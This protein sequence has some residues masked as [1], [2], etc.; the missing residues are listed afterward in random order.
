MGDIA[1]DGRERNVAPAHVH[2]ASIHGP[3]RSHDEDSRRANLVPALKLVLGLVSGYMVVEVVAGWLT[4]SLA[5]LAD[6]GHMLTDA[7]AIG[8]ALFAAWL[9]RRPSDSKRTYGYH[10]AEILAALANAVALLVIVAVIAKEAYDRLQ[11]P[12]S[13]M[14]FEMMLVAVVGLAV[15]LIGVRLLHDGS[16]HGHGLNV[17]GVFWHIVG[18]ALGSVAAIL[19]GLLIWWRG[20][21]W[22]DPACSVLICLVIVYG[23]AKLTKESVHVLMEGSPERLH[24]GE[25]RAALERLPGVRGVHDLHI[26]T[27]TSDRESL[28][29]H[30]IADDYSTS[31][32]LLCAAR[33]LLCERFA[34]DHVTIQIEPPD[35]IHAECRF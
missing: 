28:S 32:Q 8:L 4:N 23:A 3:A 17:R 18:D 33:E 19:A 21:F 12:P 26:W 24:V 29:V 30:L 6:A 11:E 9:A 7:G 1:R 25:V 34:L 22:A 15:N 10:R 20:W 2:D 13:V 31:A 27:V 35:Y 16:G 14:G 5:L